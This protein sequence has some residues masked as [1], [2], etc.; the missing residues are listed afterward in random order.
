MNQQ[1]KRRRRGH[2][3]QPAKRADDIWR[4][5]PPVP[6]V[7]PIDR[8]T[9]VSALLTSLGDPPMHNPAAA[10][11]YFGVVVERAAAVAIALALSADVL[12]DES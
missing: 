12:R 4:D 1:R 6:D 9:E 10:G 5:T 2:G 8:P 11:R 7:E 3:G